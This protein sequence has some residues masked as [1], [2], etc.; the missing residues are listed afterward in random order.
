MKVEVE[1]VSTDTIKPSSPTPHHLRNYQLSF[2]DQISPPIFMPLVFFFEADHGDQNN[3]TNAAMSN[4]FKKS[5]SETLT[6]FYPLAGRVMDNLQIDCNDAGVPYFEARANCRLSE[7][8]GDPIPGELNKFLP[9]ELDDIRDLP[10]VIQVTFFDCGGLVLSVGFSHKVADALS[11]LMFVKSW[12]GTARGDRHRPCPCFGSS[13]IFPQK[14]LSGFKPTTGIVKEKIVTKRFVFTAAKIATLRDNYTDKNGA[15]EYSR[16]PTR[17]E[18]LSAFIWSRFVAATQAK[19]DSGKIYTVLHAVNLRTRIDP[20][21]P[22]YYFGNISRVAIAVASMDSEEE[23]SFSD[24]KLDIVDR[25][26]QLKQSLSDALTRFY[27]LAGRTRANLYIDCND[28]GVPYVEAQVQCQLSV[29]VKQ[30]E[31]AELNRLLPCELDNVG[32]LLLA[33]QV[34]IFGCGGIA[35]G[36]CISHKIADAL[37]LFMFI[38]GWAATARGDS[39]IVSPNFGLATI[40]PPRKLSGFKPGTGIYKD[41]CVTKRFVFNSSM[42]AFLKRK[43][44]N[45]IYAENARSR[46]SRTEAL[47]AFIWSRFVAATQGKEEEEEPSKRLINMV[48][49]LV[50]LRTR[51]DPPLPENYFGNIVSFPMATPSMDSKEDCYGVINSIREAIKKVDGD[52]VKKL[53]GGE[54]H[55]MEDPAKKGGVVSFTFSSLCRFPI[56][57]ADFGWGKPVWVASASLTKK[58]VVLF[59]D[60]KVGNGI[61]AWINMEE[62]DMAKFQ[63]DK[64]FLALFSPIQACI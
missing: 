26:N 40:F 13:T 30:P 54:E 35:V 21:L 49:Q 62:E 50:N 39:D 1:V 3:F 28:E 51:T 4:Q 5:L 2:L 45:S 61:E 58:N 38:N 47:S 25:S 37:S 19:G 9:C 60:T 43:Y 27:P 12:A 7:V 24:S 34:N 8:V 55:F 20:P 17:I 31:P 52:Y 59:M 11:F 23:C 22:E 57:E 63:S 32:D 16:P 46:P 14:N 33:I 18:A 64:E 41:K 53:Q 42:I 29:V 56:Y 6:Q 44:T 48:C 10:M 36:L 15:E